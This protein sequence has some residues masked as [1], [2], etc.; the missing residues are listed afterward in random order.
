MID[1]QADSCP[2]PMPLALDAWKRQVQSSSR[3]RCGE[4]VEYL[5]DRGH[6]SAWVKGTMILLGAYHQVSYESIPA[7]SGWVHA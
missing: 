2:I 1:P 3:L 4:A 7:G 6:L 5:D